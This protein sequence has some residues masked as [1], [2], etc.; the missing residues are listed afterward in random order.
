MITACLCMNERKAHR[1]KAL[2]WQFNNHKMFNISP[3]SKAIAT[4][5]DYVFIC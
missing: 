5:V 2:L 4:P 3:Q 1:Q